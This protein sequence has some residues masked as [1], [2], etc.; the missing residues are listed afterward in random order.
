[1]EESSDAT[2][3]WEAIEAVR[4]GLQRATNAGRDAELRFVVQKVE[5]EFA[6]ELKRS[7]GSDAGVKAW[8]LSA[9]GRAERSVG[10]S[11]RMTVELGLADPSRL[12]KAQ[13]QPNQWLRAGP[14]HSTDAD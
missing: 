9:G 7:V 10:Q 12:I 1:M 8:V 14:S 2:E 6:V 11:H 13:G 5:L 3:L 4:E